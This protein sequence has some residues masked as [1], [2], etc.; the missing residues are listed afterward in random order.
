MVSWYLEPYLS[1]K[2]TFNKNI[3]IK[4][5]VVEKW[6]RKFEMSRIYSFFVG[7]WKIQLCLPLCIT[8]E[9]LHF[10]TIKIS[11][12]KIDDLELIFFDDFLLLERWCPK[13]PE[14]TVFEY[15]ILE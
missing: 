5:I 13:Y 12:T 4:Y 14:T 10:L 11:K 15:I 6:F 1:N 7:F 2:K 8:I 3:D 9:I